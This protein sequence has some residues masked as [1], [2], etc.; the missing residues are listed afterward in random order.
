MPRSWLQHPGQQRLPRPGWIPGL[1]S[2]LDAGSN[3]GSR[4]GRSWL[5][6]QPAAARWPWTRTGNRGLLTPTSVAASTWN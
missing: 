5:P 6:R 4:W 3:L 2:I 1:G